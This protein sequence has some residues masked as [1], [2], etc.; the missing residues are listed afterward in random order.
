MR[1]FRILISGF[2]TSL[3]ASTPLY[4]QSISIPMHKQA[5]SYQAVYKLSA[6]NQRFAYTKMKQCGSIKTTKLVRV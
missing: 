5:C 6:D 2:T 4:A 1:L 3:L